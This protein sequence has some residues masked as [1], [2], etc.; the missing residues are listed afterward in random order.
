MKIIN[1]ETGF[2]MGGNIGTDAELR[3]FAICDVSAV[4]P[5]YY[6]RILDA[7][8]TAR[9]EAEQ[10]G[11]PYRSPFPRELTSWINKYK[12]ESEKRNSPKLFFESE[13]R[14]RQIV[15]DGIW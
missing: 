4:L 6:R 3:Y 7:D 12:S 2:P 14:Y 8:K 1:A 9:Y 11:S 10:S 15:A 5:R 13:A